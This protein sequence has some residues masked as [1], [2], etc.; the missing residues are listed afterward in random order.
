MFP[1]A[2]APGSTLGRALW[3]DDEAGISDLYPASGYAGTTGSVQGT[4]TKDGHGVLGA[5]VVA[6]SLASG[7]MIGGFTLDDSG[8]FVIGGLPPGTYLLR[9]EPLDDGDVSSYLEAGNIDTDFGVAFAPELV[10]V[11]AGGSS[12]PVSV[13]VRAK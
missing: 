12:P 5:H 3:P 4:V 6:F 2:F 1:V 9:V 13:V 7:V 8:R 11:P 10:T